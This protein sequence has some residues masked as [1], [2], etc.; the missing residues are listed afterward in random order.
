MTE[1]FRAH[2]KLTTRLHVVGQRADGYHLLDA[3][4]ISLDLHD[5]LTFSP[6]EYAEVRCDHPQLAGTNDNLVLRSL[7]LLRRTASVHLE[8]RIPL[9]GGL[10]GGSSDAAAVFRW[11]RE[12]DLRLAARIGADVPF[13]VAGGRAR[14]RGIGEHLSPL[15]HRDQTFT[16]LLPPF[17][18]SSAAVF[19]M[20]DQMA[21][22]RVEHEVEE[23]N[24]LT[25]AAWKVE[26]R[27]A[28]WFERFGE[29]AGRAP[30]LA[31]SGS[32]LFVEGEVKK[33]NE[34]WLPGA[35]LLTTKAV[36]TGTVCGN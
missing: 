32:T 14:V 6:S 23:V 25:A 26:P 12:S 2:A 1:V 34:Q 30:V 3:E 19:S 28:F 36:S 4:M 22:Q 31:G 20:F 29:L 35:T 27:L 13:C 7:Q 15:P 18:V 24:Q 5:T 8:K 21:S 11:A 17:G 9:G 16:L 10:G 33:P